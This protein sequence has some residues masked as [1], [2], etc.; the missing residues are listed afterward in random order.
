MEIK[1][2]QT[3]FRFKPELLSR[4][5][6]KAR[7]EGKSLNAYVESVME[8]SLNCEPDRYE[9]IY[10]EIQSLKP[11]V[12]CK[13]VMPEFKSIPSFTEE[14]LSVDPRLE[15]LCIKHLQ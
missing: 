12:S 13:S 8:E 6:A 11:S 2:V 3:A 10:R 4:M 9:R 5:K 15:Y 1:S 14:E 7:L